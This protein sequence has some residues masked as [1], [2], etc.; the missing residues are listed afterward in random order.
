MRFLL[1]LGAVACL[2]FPVPALATSQ[3][4]QLPSS[5]LVLELDSVLQLIRHVH[6]APYR[7]I[8]QAAFD[9]QARQ[10]RAEIPRLT[11]ERA[12]AGMMRLVASLRD[13]HTTL[14]PSA[15][16]GFD[17]WLPVRFYRFT[18]GVYITAIDSSRA[19]LAGARVLRIGRLPAAEALDSAASLMGYDSDPMRQEVGA[20]MLSSPAALH[21]LGITPDSLSATFVLETRANGLQTVQIGAVQGS[22]DMGWRFWGEMFGPILSTR[23]RYGSGYVSA[24]A[25]ERPLQY[26][27]LDPAMPLHLRY[28]LYYYFAPLSPQGGVYVQINFLQEDPRESFADF[29]KRLWAYVDSAGVDRLVLDLR[30]NSGGNGDLNLPFVHE[31]IRHTSIDRPGHLYVLLGRK[32]FSAAVMLAAELATHT[33][34]VFA[35]EASGA[36]A[37]HAGDAIT[38]T[39]PRTGMQLGVSTLF[40]QLGHPADTLAYI[41]V[42]AATPFSAADYYGLRDPALDVVLGGGARPL[43]GILQGE[44]AAAARSAYAERRAR[45]AGYPW[46]RP[47]DER[48]MNETGYEL[49]AA[50]RVADAVAAFELNTAE[51]PGSWGWW[52]SLGDGYSRAGALAQAREAYAR[53]LSLNPN[54]DDTRAK[55]TALK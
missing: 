15:A 12:V 42:S 23:D 27:T 13:G 26:R 14:L 7:R 52:D 21:A 16:G 1:A 33:E 25:H 18:D 53:A 29:R 30:Y 24:I 9:S 4:P 11:E 20:L 38:V 51:H 35:G 37:N 10:L 45:Y 22:P 32:T 3:T 5:S 48:R 40:W 47:F 2:L 41:P 6:P 43:T 54:A 39:M 17:R 36:G 44:G 19:T 50:G 31:I 49:L 28:R 55:L 46:W 8:P 34:A